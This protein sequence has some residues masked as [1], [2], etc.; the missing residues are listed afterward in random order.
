MIPTITG[1]LYFAIEVVG[2]SHYQKQFIK[3]CGAP[4]PKGYNLKVQVHLYLENENPHDSNAVAVL[5]NG[6]KVGHLP[7]NTAKDFRRAVIAGDL[8]TH[9]TFECEGIIKGGWDKGNGDFGLFGI[10]L[11]LPQDDD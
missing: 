3:H 6:G 7:K 2:E 11:D 5:L 10:W 4:R 1:P 8:G 9:K